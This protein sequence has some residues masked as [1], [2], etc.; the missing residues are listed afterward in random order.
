M[1]CDELVEA[2]V[3]LNTPGFEG[4]KS[5]NMAHELNEA[6]GPLIVGPPLP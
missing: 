3:D 5:E 2:A 6:C 4:F 1:L